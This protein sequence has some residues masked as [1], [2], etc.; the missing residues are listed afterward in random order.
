MI[1]NL[2]AYEM[3]GQRR[4]ISAP[5]GWKHLVG[6]T[7]QCHIQL[8]GQEVP[9]V[10]FSFVRDGAGGVQ[11][12]DENDELFHETRLPLKLDVLGMP[13]VLFEPR[14]LLESPYA[15]NQSPPTTLM[16]R[17]GDDFAP[18]SVA[19]GALVCA[20]CAPDADIVLPDGPNYAY[21]LWWDGA[22]HLYIA[23]LDSS[24]GG[25][26]MAGGVWGQQEV[27]QLPITLNAGPQICELGTSEPISGPSTGAYTM[28]NPPPLPV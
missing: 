7:E 13:V 20:G 27:V 15:V 2:I 24:E 12:L 18:L 28:A 16:L 21:A 19:P 9:K 10:L 11:V 26:W 25:A 1:E 22:E 14:D 5:P 23:V 4:C 3:A 17:T 6:S 8:S